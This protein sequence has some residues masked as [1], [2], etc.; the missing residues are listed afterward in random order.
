MKVYT[1]KEISAILK[2]SPQTIRKYIKKGKIKAIDKPGQMLVTEV[3]LKK[4][5]NGGDKK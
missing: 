2:L 4:F 5:L 1:V 3:N